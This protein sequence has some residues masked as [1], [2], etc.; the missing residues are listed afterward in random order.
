MFLFD[1]R[2][3]G[4]DPLRT[5][6]RDIAIVFGRL[7]KHETTIDTRVTKVR[8]KGREIKLL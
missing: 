8:D 5:E 2:I 3:K 1:H 7:R 4:I 6:E